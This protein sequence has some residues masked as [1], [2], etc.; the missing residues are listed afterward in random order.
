VDS[1]LI[2]KDYFYFF[3]FCEFLY[4]INL[5]AQIYFTNIF[6]S[7]QFTK[8]GLEWLTYN[9]EQLD[10]KYDPLIKV[11][12]RMTKCLF[13]KYGYSGSIERHDALCFLPLNIVNEKIYVVLWFWYV[14]IFI[15]TSM[16]LFQRVALILC[17][18]IRFY[19]LRQLAPSTDKKQLEKLTS[20][21][22][23][24]FILHLLANNMRPYYFKDMIEVVVKEHFD[25]DTKTNGQ[26]PNVLRRAVMNCLN[27]IN[28]SKTKDHKPFGKKSKHVKNLDIGFVNANINAPPAGF[29]NNNREPPTGHS[30]DTMNNEWMIRNNGCNW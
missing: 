7:G 23:N 17:P 18:C 2:S 9:H 22:G 16:C 15:V 3:F 10:N 4:F 13:H 30:I 21:V 24:F 26:P 25:C 14:F 19:K 27:K 6:L 1:L 12:P 11:F 29:V 28:V 5:I 8:L 20:T